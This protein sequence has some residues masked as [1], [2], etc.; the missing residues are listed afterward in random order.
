M[1]ENGTL[2]IPVVRHSY[3][4]INLH[5]E[6]IKKLDRKARKMPT[7]HGQRHP[8]ADIARVYVPRKEGGRELM[9]A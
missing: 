8:I 3:G 7:V 4:I 1:Q 5:Q 2:L 9:Q 6:E